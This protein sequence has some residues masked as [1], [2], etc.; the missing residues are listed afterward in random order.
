MQVTSNQKPC[1][2]EECNEMLKMFIG[3]KTASLEFYTQQKYIS[4]LKIKQ[5]F[6]DKQKQIYLS[7]AFPK[8]MI[9]GVLQSEGKYRKLEAWRW[10]KKWKVTK[11]NISKTKWIPTI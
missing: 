9:K 8:E 1:K 11:E 3:K 4:N 2:E 7:L 6:S 5:T 10:R